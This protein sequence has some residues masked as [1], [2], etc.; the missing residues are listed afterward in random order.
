YFTAGNGWNRDSSP[1][2]GGSRP[3]RSPCC[4]AHRSRDGRRSRE[5]HARRVQR[6]CFETDSG[7]G[8]SVFRHTENDCWHLI[9]SAR[10]MGQRSTRVLLIE[11][12]ESDYLLTRRTLF[13]IASEV[14][15]LEWASSWQAGIEAVRRAAYDVCLLDYRIGGADGLELLK[16]ARASSKNA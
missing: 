9:C 13:S 11:D 8:Y 4:C 6:V 3:A 12:S 1:N 5:V 14:F 15:D 2:S 16:E 7:H 10:C